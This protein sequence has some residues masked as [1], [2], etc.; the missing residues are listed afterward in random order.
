[1]A[2]VLVIDDD[3]QILAMLRIMLEN[4]G[5]E[6]EVA[7][8]GQKGA[9]LY[10]ANPADV[11]I[12]DI[13]MPEK[14]GIET[15]IELRR[16][17]PDVRIIAMSGGGRFGPDHFLQLAKSLGAMKTLSK[18]FRREEIITAVAEVLST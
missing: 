13:I 15:I 18:P 16:E 6:V 10:R 11:I 7:S 14:E 2:R 8:N 12:T 3:E 1:M 9:M 17:Y 5:Y 4:E